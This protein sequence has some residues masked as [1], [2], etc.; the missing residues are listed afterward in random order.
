MADPSHSSAR[1]EILARVRQKLGV[2]GDEPGRRGKVRSNLVNPRANIIPERAQKPRAEAIKLFQ[3]MLQKSGAKVS[4]VRAM[5]A[6]PEAIAAALKEQNL[7]LRL[8]AGNDPVF[9][10]LRAS[11]GLFE[12]LAGPA[13]PD[14]TVALSRAFGAAAETGTM[15]FTSGADNPS[16]LNFLTENHFAIILA[17]DISGS[18]EEVWA[19]IRVQYGPGEMPRT[20]S[21]ISG[22]SRTT[23]IEQ[24][25]I[26][27]AHGPKNLVVFIVGS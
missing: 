4:R 18:Y 8:R 13:S 26:L 22:P 15:F 11:A 20:V 17:E 1:E 2:R 21:L 6:L 24:T 19:K 14:D 25:I 10:S 23:S 5:R 12:L 3:T 27:G 9:S 7:P 16:T